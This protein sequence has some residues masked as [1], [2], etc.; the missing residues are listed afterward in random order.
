M[1]RQT[2][3]RCLVA[4]L[5]VLLVLVGGAAHAANGYFLH[6]YSAQQRAL[7]GAGTAGADDAFAGSI[8]PALLADIDDRLDLDLSLLV[9][10]G[11]LNVVNEPDLEP[12]TGAGLF[13][14]NPTDQAGR[15][16]GGNEGANKYFPIPGVAFARRI[17]EHSAWGVAIYG[18]GGLNP[19]F[20]R[21]SGGFAQ[22]DATNLLPVAE[23]CEGIFGGGGN[24]GQPG[25]LGL[26][27]NGS[28]TTLVNLTQLFV[29]TTYARRFGRL[30]V[31]VAPLFMVQRFDA[32]GLGAFARFSQNPDRVTENGKDYSFGLGVRVG[33][34]YEPTAWLRLGASYQT[35]THATEFDKY[36]GLFARDGAF[37]VPSSFNVGIALT[38]AP[39]HRLLIDYQR[40]NFSNVAALGNRLRP[41]RFVNGCVRPVLLGGPVD[42]DTCLGGDNAPGFGWRDV[43]IYKFGYE[44]RRGNVTWRLGFSNNTQP[45]RNSDILLSTLAFAVNE[46][47][48]TA[49]L[50]WR[51]SR[52]WGLDVA[53]AYSPVKR[54]VGKNPL[55]HIEGGVASI[56]AGGENFGIDPR[57]QDIQGE[58]YF[59]EATIGLNWHFR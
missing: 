26:C 28:S 54:L 48:Y 8:N 3:G 37:D 42:F 43:T 56:V 14:M 25:V 52:S 1:D 5:L 16:F 44:Y 12:V 29:A 49:G 23:R 20:T 32:S 11:T 50:S 38:P 34:A 58:F 17:D 15:R 30:R 57:D 9:P 55:S 36:R 6:G 31:G 7:A 18:N 27:G 4:G 10:I 53:L 33:M 47:H 22:G 2:P 13:Q 41:N 24:I 46:Y 45:V 59:L 39:R 51:F 19:K 40:I 35:R 21:G